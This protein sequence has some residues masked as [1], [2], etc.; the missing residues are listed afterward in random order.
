MNTPSK[1]NERDIL[2]QNLTDEQLQVV[3]EAST[4]HTGSAEDLMTTAL[5][6]MIASK[7]DTLSRIAT[8]WSG[9]GLTCD[10]TS[11]GPGAACDVCEISLLL[12]EAGR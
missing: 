6:Q 3:F 1:P 9:L 5:R 10:C 8:A 12:Q 11:R 7:K 2:F 4:Y